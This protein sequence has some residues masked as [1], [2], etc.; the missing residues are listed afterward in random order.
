MQ[1]KQIGIILLIGL[2]TLGVIGAGIPYTTSQFIWQSTDLNYT[3]FYAGEYDGN[4]LIIDG[5]IFTIF[6]L[7]GSGGG[8][9]LIDTNFETA[10]LTLTGSNTGDQNLYK[11]ENNIILNAFRI[12]ING[13]LAIFNMID[14]VVDEYEDETGMNTTTSTNEVYDALGDFYTQT[15]SGNLGTDLVS[16]WKLNDN[17]LNTDVIDDVGSNDGTLMGGSNTQDVTVA[18]PTDTTP[19]FAFNGDD[20]YVSIPDSSSLSGIS[21]QSYSAWIKKDVVSTQGILSKDDGAGGNREMLLMVGGGNGTLYYYK[22]SSD[23]SNYLFARGTTRVDDGYWHHVVVIWDGVNAN[24]HITFYVDGVSDTIGAFSSSGTGGVV[25]DSTADFEIGRYYGNNNYTWDGSIDE[26]RVYDRVLTQTEV[27][28]LY[29]SGNGTESAST[30]SGTTNMTLI[31]EPVTAEAEPDTARIVIL[32]EDVDAV[33]INTDLTAHAS[34]DGG[35]T[36]DLITLVDEGNYDSSTRILTGETDLT[37]TGTNMVYKL[38]TANTK[39]LKI[40]GTALTW[41]D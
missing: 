9:T 7:N 12:A 13:S 33:T 18:G 16:R 1:T 5:N 40:H 32:E 10:G 25:H 4:G 27:T 23:Y 31:S 21:A 6:D 11:I 8:G 36:W 38:T 20:D 37:S 26:V 14:G 22:Y 19:G 34:R 28:A 3:K 17:A 39:N 30:S 2:L 41:S 24:G 35:A 29:N 15:S